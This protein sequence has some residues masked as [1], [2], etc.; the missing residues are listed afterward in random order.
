MKTKQIAMNMETKLEYLIFIDIWQ[1]YDVIKW[2]K[3]EKKRI[4][5]GIEDKKVELIELEK[6]IMKKT[7]RRTSLLT[8]E[9]VREFLCYHFYKRRYQVEM[10]TSEILSYK[11]L[12]P[13]KLGSGNTTAWYLRW[14]W[15]LYQE[16]RQCTL[17][18]K[19][20]RYWAVKTLVMVEV[21][22]SGFFWPA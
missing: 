17:S 11:R 3:L 7:G 15:R 13:K 12:Y 14:T 19:K 20:H 16:I 21:A 18:W 4:E 5:L 22:Q 8:N 1:A 2:R 9:I 6:Q 10:A